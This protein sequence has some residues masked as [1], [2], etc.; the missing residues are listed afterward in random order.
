MHLRFASKRGRNP[1]HPSSGSS[2]DRHT[3]NRAV[4]RRSEDRDWNSSLQPLLRQG[5]AA[6]GHD[7]CDNGCSTCG[8][9]VIVTWRDTPRSRLHDWCYV[10]KSLYVHGAMA[11]YMRFPIVESPFLSFMARGT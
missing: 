2:L 7:G 4:P 8:E 1:V 10:Q 6:V 3:D 9:F 11:K 5:L